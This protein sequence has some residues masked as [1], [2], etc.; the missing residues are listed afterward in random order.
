MVSVVAQAMRSQMRTTWGTI[1]LPVVN[2]MAVI[3]KTVLT[4]VIAI[5]G[6]ATIIVIVIA[7]STA[8]GCVGT[9]VYLTV[10]SSTT[11]SI[12]TVMV[13]RT[14]LVTV[15]TQRCLVI[16]VSASGERVSILTG[17]ST[18]CMVRVHLHYVL[19]Q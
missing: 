14:L 2:V 11:S 10:L 19:V 4:I 16:I 7:I 8:M 15:V 18:S 6:S 13:N 9:I 3:M 17:F 1:T 12:A 5:P